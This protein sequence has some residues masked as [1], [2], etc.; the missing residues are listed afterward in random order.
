[1]RQGVNQ[2][3]LCITL[4]VLRKQISTKK[5]ERRAL[6]RGYRKGEH[7]IVLQGAVDN[8][9]RFTDIYVG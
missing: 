9:G 7:S 2:A 8:N 6:E 4:F 1:M 5:A 3:Y